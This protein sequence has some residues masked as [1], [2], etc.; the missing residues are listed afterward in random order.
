VLAHARKALAKRQYAEALRSAESLVRARVDDSVRGPALLIAA[1]ASF[2]MQAYREAAVRYGEFITAY[3]RSPEAPRAA[4]ARGWSELRA[5]QRDRARQAW[6]QVAARFPADARAPLALALAAEIGR[7]TGDVTA[8]NQLVVRYA[9]SPYAGIARLNR[10]IAE[11][12]AQREDAAVRDLEEAI[13]AHG[14]VVIEERRRL[15]EAIVTPSKAPVDSPLPPK[16]SAGDKIDSIERV[17]RLVDRRD[18]DSAPYLLH[19]LVLLAATNRGW[20]NALTLTVTERLA[21][22]FPSYPATPA[23]LGRIGTSATTAGQWQVARKA[24]EALAVRYPNT[25]P[26]RNARVQ[27]AEALYRTGASGEARRVLRQAV[28]VAKGG[29]AAEA[30][31]RLGQDLRAEGQHAA[32]VEWYLTAAYVAER[33]RWGHQA[34]LAAGT[35]LSALGE[36]REALAVYLRLVANDGET[37]GEAAYRAAEIYSAAGLHEDALKMYMTSAQ[38]TAGSRAESRAL[39]GAAKILVATGDRAGAEALYQRLM[40]SRAAEPT[41]VMQLRN[42]LRANGGAAGA[43]PSE[44]ALPKAAR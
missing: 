14:T 23:L 28:E 8:D 36:R 22:V 12:R 4:M 34:L 13:R 21:E 35:S 25:P 10:S 16:S 24:Y 18:G 2:A 3:A 17:A 7:Q 30:A 33:S 15:A 43:T 26:A 1:D 9:A 27:L 39:V 38:L 41:L 31:Y 11:V 40:Q 37:G 19:C 32:A 42:V 20:S 29:D 44:S 5:G 6:T